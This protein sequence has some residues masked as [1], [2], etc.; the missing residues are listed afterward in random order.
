MTRDQ[1]LAAAVEMDITPPVGTRFAGYHAREGISLGVHDPLLAQLLLLQSGDDHIVLI[2]MD[3]LAVGLGFARRVRAGIEEA[4]GVP[5]CC[6]MIACSHTHSGPAG[7]LPPL[8]DV[9]P[10]EDPELQSIAARKLIGA[11]V[12]LR[13]CLQPAH[14]GVGRV[15]LPAHCRARLLIAGA[16]SWETVPAP[17]A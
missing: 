10:P 14:L 7:F 1:L 17:G 5:G 8:T 12:W 6:T 16:G 9:R 4:I 11:A 3:L 15:L 13:E 2:T